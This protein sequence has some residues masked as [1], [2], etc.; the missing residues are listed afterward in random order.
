M[1]DNSIK[2]AKTGDFENPKDQNRNFNIKSVPISAVAYIGTQT[3]ESLYFLFYVKIWID[4]ERVY[5]GLLS[6]LARSL[7]NF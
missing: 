5:F 6:I 2:G 3:G 4:Q 7:Y 1:I